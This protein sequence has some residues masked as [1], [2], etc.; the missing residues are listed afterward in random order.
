MNRR[1]LVALSVSLTLVVS[2]C[3]KKAPPTVAPEPMAQPPAAASNSAGNNTAPP[4]AATNPMGANL[5]AVAAG[6]V[7]TIADRIHFDYNLADIKAED[8][9]RLDGKAQLLKQFTT[10]R[11][12]ITGHCDER[13]SDQYNIALGMR[14]ATA[15]KDYL[16]Q[17]GIDASRIE[18]ASLGREVP[19]DAASTEAAW[20]QNRRD[21][22]D[23][24]AGSQSLRAP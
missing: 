5:D 1:K 21:E 2:A 4:P 18:V 13:G 19:I 6:R 15:A 23:I 22:F 24:V 3:H 14:R 20:A 9:S 11:I 16:V 10:V 8:R 17:A 7:N 12:R